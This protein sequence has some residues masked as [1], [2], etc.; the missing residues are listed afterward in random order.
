MAPMDGT[1]GRAETEAPSVRLQTEFQTKE[2]SSSV[3]VSTQQACI[4]K[5][6]SKFGVER[7]SAAMQDLADDFE[8]LV[9]RVLRG[10]FQVLQQP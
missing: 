2:V 9:L 1:T 8:G 6:F 10:Q 5:F 4:R 7:A 3:G